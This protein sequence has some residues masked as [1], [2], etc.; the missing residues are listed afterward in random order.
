MTRDSSELSGF[1]N[2]LRKS[3]GAA[4]PI[5]FPALPKEPYISKN[6]E[7]LRLSQKIFFKSSLKLEDLKIQPPLKDDSCNRIDIITDPIIL[8]FN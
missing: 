2:N 3:V 7:N 6:R 8:K 4:G 5:P 1:F